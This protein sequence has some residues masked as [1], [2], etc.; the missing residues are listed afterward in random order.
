MSTA[1][2]INLAD[3]ICRRL[4][5]EINGGQLLPGD[6]LDE[7]ELAARFGVSRTPIREAVSQLAAQGLVTSLPRQGVY[8]A[9]MSIQELLALFELLA[10]LEGICA[11]Y[12]ARRMTDAQ[13]ARLVAVHQ[14][15]TQHVEAEDARGYSQSN[16]DFHELLYMGCHNVF[17]AQQLR[18]IRRR[19]QMYRQNSF[20]QPGRMR[21]S[22]EDHQ[23]V[24]DAILRGDAEEA[25]QQMIEHIS[26]GGKG[27]AEFVSTLSSKMFE[28]HDIAYPKA[29]ET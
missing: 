12:G 22:S 24:L 9:R 8:V 4:E 19:T 7:R 16:V 14:K 11:K 6:A 13:R 27:F 18:A 29:S 25:Q 20:L 17:L 5:E 2:K 3:E 1:M 10:E 28:S 21:I 15:S 23:R 26:V